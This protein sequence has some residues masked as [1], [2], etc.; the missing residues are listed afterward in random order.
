MAGAIDHKDGIGRKELNLIRD[1]FLE[2]HNKRRQRIEGELRPSQRA[3]LDLLPLLFHINN[4]MLPGYVSNETPAGIP[5]YTPNRDTILAAKSLSRSFTYEKRAM[6]SFQIL[7]L[8]LMGSIGSIAHTSGSDFD[9][10]LCY[11]PTLGKED[12]LE[13]RE[14]VVKIETWATELA[15]EVHIFLVNVDTF[16]SGTRDAL[17]HESSGTAQPNLLLEEFYRTAVW[18]AGRYPLW[19][20]IPPES[21]QEYSQYAQMLVKKR[22]VDPLEFLD[23]G[24][25]EKLP[26]KEFFGAAHWQLY[27]GI[28]SP[29]KSVLK[30][31]LTES[32]AQEYPDIRWLCQES[33][34]AVYADTI[35]TTDLDPYIMMYQRVEQFLLERNEYKRLDLARRCF[36]FKAEQV[37][38]RQYKLKNERWQR[39]LI[40]NL[41]A[42]WKWDQA[43][44]ITLDSRSNWKIDQV[45]EE[46]NILVR[47]LTHSYRLLTNFARTFT[48]GRG[49]DPR[50]LSLLGRK[51]Y[52]TLEK[53][54]GKVDLINPGIS[55]NLIESQV[56]VHHTRG[57]AGEFGWHLYLGDVDE[58]EA[59]VTRPVKTTASLIEMLTWC[60][61]NTV[62]DRGTK[63]S[64]HPV[65][66]PV[67]PEELYALLNTIR[68]HY[69]DHANHDEVPIEQLEAQP[70]TKSCLLFPNIGTDPMARL[71][72]SGKQLTS[73]RS[74][75]L[76]FGAA[77]TSLVESI[78]LLTQTSWGEHLVSRYSGLDGLFESLCNYMR[79]TLSDHDGHPS[80]RVTAHCFKSTR[81]EGIAKR[82]ETLFNDTCDC[83]G[84]QGSGIDSRYLLQGGDSYYVIQSKQDGYSYFSVK[85]W[86]ELLE[87]LSLPNDRFRPV[88]IDRHALISTPLPAIYSI[89]K[90]GVIQIFYIT[91][92]QSSDIFVLD[93][94]GSLFHQRLQGTDEHYLVAQQQRFFNGLL[95]LRSLL[96][97]QPADPALLDEPEFYRLG[98]SREGRFTTQKRRLSTRRLPENYLELRAVS[99][100]LDLNL[101]PF[102]LAC[103]DLEFSSLEHGQRLYE[104][105]ARHVVSQRKNRQ[106]YPIYLTALELSG[107]EVERSWSTIELL[108]YKKRLEGRLNQALQQIF[109]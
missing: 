80:P 18:L 11:N 5:L 22:F 109:S 53:R 29:Y 108:K 58:L 104:I 93:E 36:Y 102:V 60:H 2:V 90:A 89:N 61:L 31:L 97:D 25:L 70:F 32:Y 20:M 88:R 55:V 14:K 28:Q 3:F 73:N 74:D 46:R 81:A 19:W 10:W 67:K 27:K 16:R 48:R 105:V 1:R 45:L 107:S 38:S 43:K 37:L 57:Q 106:T 35:D 50:E 77:H 75:P 68:N 103:G 78:D 12:I 71:S 40:K 69:S 79:L 83:F 96:A 95:L 86:H 4:P 52:T 39:T 34:N 66:C 41:T 63:I 101:T 23:F 51:L 72:R 98:K 64:I 33:K 44:L 9:V 99:S 100:G 54:P 87:T 47:E 6:R 76:S 56:S 24:G 42:E 17:S 84:P 85:S 7:G 8:Y 62:V 92:K 21:E 91:G 13:L 15:L 49:I 59:D 65:K 82:V 94:N 26:P 30:L